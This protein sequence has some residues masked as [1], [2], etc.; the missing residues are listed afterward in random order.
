MKYKVTLYFLDGEN[1]TVTVAGEKMD[2]F[3]AAIGK[4][5]VYYDDE[6]KNGVW[7]H[8][9]QLRFFTING[10]EDEM[11]PRIEKVR[12][13]NPLPEEPP[14]DSDQGSEASVD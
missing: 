7:V 1:L 11:A 4:N 13:A 10:E 2:K 12:S 14:A 6:T 9:D 8:L 5:E 3:C